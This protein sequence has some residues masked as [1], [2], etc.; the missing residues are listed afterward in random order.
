RRLG[1]KDAV[2]RQEIAAGGDVAREGVVEHDQVVATRKLAHGR[3]LEAGQ[4]ARVPADVDVGMRL[5]ESVQ[6]ADQWVHRAPVIPG[7]A[8]Q[9]NLPHGASLSLTSES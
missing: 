8:L 9:S 7:H 5:S 6:R 4:R 2:E 1:R 3:E